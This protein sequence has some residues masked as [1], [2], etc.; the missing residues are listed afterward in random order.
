ML[1][2][3]ATSN[4]GIRVSRSVGSMTGLYVKGR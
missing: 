1:R 4:T 2:R 3:A